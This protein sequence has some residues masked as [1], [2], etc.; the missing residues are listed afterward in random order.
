MQPEPMRMTL[1]EY[2]EWES[3]RPTKYEFAD[4]LVYAMAGA[5]DAHQQIVVNLA[6]IIR[7]WLRGTPCRIYTNDMK[8]VPSTKSASRYPDLLVT[9][10]A[11]D[12][13]DALVKR[14]PKLI[15]EVLS[16]RTE[17]FDLVDKLDEYRSISELEEYVLVDS[18]RIAIRAY[19]RFGEDWVLHEY[20]TSDRILRLSTLGQ[21]V[22]M[23]Q[24]YED[25][26]LRTERTR[27]V[28]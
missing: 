26:Q 10:D 17:R 12:H 18:R 19:R 15:V 4:G 16:K 24:I 3:K 13:E 9:C 14:H 22:P 7:P 20:A 8:V 27:P 2:L 28:R 6:A 5:T 11:R 21:D 23:E 1:D 25:V